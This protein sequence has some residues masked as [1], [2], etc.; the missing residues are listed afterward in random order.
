VET[1]DRPNNSTNLIPWFP[2]TLYTFPEDADRTGSIMGSSSS[3]EIK[4]RLGRWDAILLSRRAIALAII[5][6]VIMLVV[7]IHRHFSMYP[8]YASFDQGIF[9]QLFW[10]SVRGQF[11]QSSLSSTLSSS[12]VHDGQLPEV[13]YHRLGQHFTPA[14]A[15][16]FPIYFIVRSPV[17][18]LVLQ[19]TLV[20]LAGLVLYQLARQRL[21][22]QLSTL[23]TSSFYGANAVIGPSLANFHDLCQM[24]LFMFTL[25][26]ALEKRIWWL[27]WLMAVLVLMIR[28]DAGVTLFSVGFYLLVSRRYP[29]LGLA[30]CVLSFGYMLVL[31]NYIMPLFSEDISRRFMIEQFGQY[32]DTPEAS[33]VDVIWGMMR[34]PWRLF[35][36]IVTPVWENLRYLLGHW[37][38]LMFV[39]AIAPSSWA[40]AAFPL[41]QIYLRQDPTALSINLRYAMTVVPG[42]FYGAILWWS[43]HPQAFGGFVKRFWVVCISLSLIFTVTSNPNRALSFMI[44]DSIEP[45]IYVSP[46]QQWHHVGVIRSMMAQIPPTASASASTHIIPHLSSRREL[47]RFPLVQLRN[48]AEEEVWAEYVLLDLE[49]MKV[50]QAAFE[51]DLRELKQTMK[52]L[53]RLLKQGR[54]GILQFQ[55]GALFL[56]LDADSNPEAIA[57]WTEY[58]QSLEPILSQGE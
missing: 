51:D 5:F 53:D 10:N 15:L 50:Y 20:T 9:N 38:P 19:I 21:N 37:L 36:E 44:P 4:I 7:L 25:F 27:F 41:L 18:L 31:T 58:R 47:L 3:S 17:T 16:W 40:L 26:L 30:T 35:V 12:V 1:S 33:T 24:S 13:F 8:S 29:K 2:R 6:W 54:Y 43:A 34:N 23:I 45:W 42:M 56:Q 28:E 48:D 22:P 49:Q 14:L 57:P 52:P 39:P 32:V 11:F 46:M 55:E